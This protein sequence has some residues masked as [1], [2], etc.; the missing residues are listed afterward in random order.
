MNG[1]ARAA[2]TPRI[3]QKDKKFV[4]TFNLTTKFHKQI[5]EF[6]INYRAQVKLYMLFTLQIMYSKRNI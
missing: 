2:N 3:R 4:K 5:K 6:A 1:C